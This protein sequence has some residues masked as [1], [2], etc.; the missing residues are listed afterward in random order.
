M[1]SA[2]TPVTAANPAVALAIMRVLHV[3]GTARVSGGIEVY[4]QDLFQALPS[5][6]F[7][8]S[9]AYGSD[10]GGSFDDLHRVEGLNESPMR[11][12]QDGAF[13]GMTQLADRL[14]PD[15]IHV[16]NVSNRNAI[17][18]CL[19]AAPVFVHFHDYRY[20]CPAS[21]FYFRSTETNCQ[22]VA[23]LH[24]I[25]RGCAF[26]C[27]SRRPDVSIPALQRVR[28]MAENFGRFAGL[29]ANSRR[30]Q[31]RM[32]SAGAPPR[33]STVLN[34]FC[35]YE[36]CDIL[37][38][39]TEPRYVLF[40]GRFTEQKGTEDF[41]R[42]VGLLPSDVRGVMIGDGTEANIAMIRR[43]AGE[44]GCADRLELRHWLSRSEV[45]S[46]ISGASATI[47]PS[48]WEEP[49]GLVGVESQALGVPVVAYAHG[50][51]LDWLED[52]VSGLAVRPRDPAALAA[53]VLRILQDPELARSLA[54]GGRD[55][56][57]SLFDR[58]RHLERISAL[59]RAAAT[60]S[61]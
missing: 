51:V 13:R 20:L 16:H 39:P 47:F 34:Y 55:S 54:R 3:N 19:E 43:V 58:R 2:R 10:E 27:V 31:E 29:I 9:L 25:A 18:A 37:P 61:A 6:G 21:S 59:Y 49:F 50:G 32:I 24:C 56:V 40:V 12:S 5:L 38:R 11:A 48:I 7:H 41:V 60:K 8:C 57:A 4:L 17:A 35:T 33:L 28:W 30:V 42:C 26:H 23:G 52:G 15:V 14:R 44:V 53:C 1:A 22:R 46:A 36:P 45:S